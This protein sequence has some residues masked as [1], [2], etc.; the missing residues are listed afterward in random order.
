MQQPSLI[1]TVLNLSVPG[2]QNDTNNK[3]QQQNLSNE[4]V[5]KLNMQH[6]R[7]TEQLLIKA[8]YISIAVRGILMLYFKMV[9][10]CYLI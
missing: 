8:N 4:H 10:N 2:R 9:G 1:T 6:H 5:D 7:S 3:P